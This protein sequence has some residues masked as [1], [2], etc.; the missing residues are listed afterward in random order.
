MADSELILGIDPGSRATGYG[1]IYYHSATGFAHVASGVIRTSTRDSFISR[2]K[3]LYDG[4]HGVICEFNP[5]VAAI[6]EVFVSRNVQSALKLGH[7]R[8]AAIMAVLNKGLLVYEYS[9]LEIKKAVVGYGRAEKHQVQA[10]V[11]MILNLQH[12]PP[13]DASDALA[14]AVCHANNEKF[15]NF[16]ELEVR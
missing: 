9:P 6:E 8:A 11:S 15:N 7:A 2:L 13:R 4:I 1:L 12:I 3:C 14:V 16:L 5:H 10:M